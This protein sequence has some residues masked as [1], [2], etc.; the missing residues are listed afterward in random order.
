MKKGVAYIAKI[1]IWTKLFFGM[2]FAFGYKT[3]YG[4]TMKKVFLLL[5]LP[6]LAFG[7]A[8]KFYLSVTQVRYSQKDDALQITTRLFIDDMNSVLKER[9]G[10]DA[11]LG[12]NEERAMDVEYLEKYVRAK[13]SVGI[14]GK[15]AD[16]TFIG[17]KYDADVLICY[18]EVPKVDFPN[19]S[20]ITIE[21]EIL[22]DLFEDQQN[23]LHFNINGK[24]KSYVLLKS[25][26]KGMLNL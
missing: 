1:M 9:Y 20:S 2:L 5:L 3:F 4:P 17:K 24:K 22:T 8:H 16:Y 25:D 15:T 21:N 7:T 12:G 13:F 19:I 11:R 10:L 18:L 6:L 23:V 14:N 26:T